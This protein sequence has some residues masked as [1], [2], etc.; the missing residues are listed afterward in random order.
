MNGELCGERFAKDTGE[1]RI[2]V[3]LLLLSCLAVLVVPYA[4]PRGAGGVWDSVAYTGTARNLASGSGFYL[5]YKLPPAPFTL[6]PPLYPMILAVPAYFGVDPAESAPWINGFFLGCSVFLTGFIAWAYC[7]RSYTIGFL[8]ALSILLS[9]DIV[10]IHSQVL[11]EPPFITLVLASIALLLAYTESGKT[12]HLMGLAIAMSAALVTRYAGLFFL[13]AVCIII[14][15]RWP[16][17]KRRTVSL[18]SVS[19]A[20]L[21]AVLPV[22]IWILH[23]I[24]VKGGAVGE[25]KLV[26]HRL[27]LQH[28]RELFTTVSLWFAPVIVPRSL[29][30]LILAALLVAVVGT[31]PSLLRVEGRKTEMGFGSTILLAEICVVFEAAYLIFLALTICFVDAST[32]FDMR[33]LLP[34]FPVTVLLLVS[35]LVIRREIMSR[36]SIMFRALLAIGLVVVLSNAVRFSTKIRDIRAQGIGFQTAEWQDDEIMGFVR[37]LPD[38]AILY[39]DNPTLIYYA[40][41]RAAYFMPTK[42]AIST[43]LANGEYESEMKSLTDLGAHKRVVIVLFHTNWSDGPFPLLAELTQRWGFQPMLRSVKGNYVFTAGGGRAVG[44]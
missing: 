22:G 21:V 20:L 14:A 44:D 33:L 4:V 31:F 25:R 10:E 42:F 29:R 28:C 11:S 13:A 18:I 6:W 8:A 3:S 19:L 41:Q 17:L 1:K 5:A 15:V 43:K 34:L 27:G 2:I 35:C 16:T 39:S 7:G 26:F 9:P 24:L 32:P 36:T 23:N 40:T 37:H 12:E 30:S 38:Q